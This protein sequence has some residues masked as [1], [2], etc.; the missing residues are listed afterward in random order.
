MNKLEHLKHIKKKPQEQRTKADWRFMA[1]FYHQLHTNAVEDLVNAIAD[2]RKT[3]AIV[4][5]TAPIALSI[6]LNMN[7][8]LSM[9]LTHGQRNGIEMAAGKMAEEI[10][11]NL[12][13]A[14]VHCYPVS[15]ARGQPPEDFQDIP[16]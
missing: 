4:D 16:F 8:S 12:T 5:A 2:L 7:H 15:F 1:N 9:D 11:N 6:K 14:M 3:H 10:Y 13:K